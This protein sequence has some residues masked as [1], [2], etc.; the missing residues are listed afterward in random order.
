M[1]S[2]P[3]QMLYCCCFDEI[4]VMTLDKG[5]LSTSVAQILLA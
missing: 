5:M 1:S 3:R 2:G 4:A